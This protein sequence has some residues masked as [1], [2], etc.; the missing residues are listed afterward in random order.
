MD[1]YDRDQLNR[2]L[3]GLIRQKARSRLRAGNYEG[4]PTAGPLGMMSQTMPTAEEQGAFTNRNIARAQFGQYGKGGLERQKLGQEAALSREGL[5]SAEKVAGITDQGS[6]ARAKMTEDRLS[7]EAEMK[8]HPGDAFTPMGTEHIAAR[9]QRAYYESLA[10]QAKQGGSKQPKI[11]QDEVYDDKG[12]QQTTYR[13]PIYDPQTGQYSMQT[14]PS[15]QGDSVVMQRQP[16]NPETDSATM[17]RQPYNPQEAQTSRRNMGGQKPSAKELYDAMP[18][19]QQ[20]YIRQELL[21]KSGA[22]SD[23]KPPKKPLLPEAAE[24]YKKRGKNS[25]EEAMG[26]DKLRARLNSNPW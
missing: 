24:Y 13:M 5:R 14:L 6:T 17:Q 21:K 12:Q 23:P 10:E 26:F 4:G 16:Y 9:A 15:R 20:E 22:K 8:Y 3:M 18:P 19:E 1:S 25:F 11:Y 7:K 2:E